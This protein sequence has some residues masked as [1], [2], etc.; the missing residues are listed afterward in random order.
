MLG[1]LTPVSAQSEKNEVERSIDRENLPAKALALIDEFWPDLRGIRY[2]E[3][4]GGEVLVYEVKLEWA[5]SEYSIEFSVDG[6]ILDVEKVINFND[7]PEATRDA[8]TQDLDSQFNRYRLIRVQI[9]YIHAD[10]DDDDSDFIDDILEQ[11]ADDYEIRYEIEVDGENRR[12]LGS[13]ELLYSESG[14]LIQKRRIIRRSI[15]NIW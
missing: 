10:D 14:S 3:Q 4:I 2:F 8:I 9:Q 6:N 13:F 1:V 7:V 5:G 15:D 12:E 11:D